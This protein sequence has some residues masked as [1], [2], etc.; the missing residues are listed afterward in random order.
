MRN[1]AFGP[2]WQ[3]STVPTRDWTVEHLRKYLGGRAFTLY[4]H[5]TC[6]V[7]IGPG[8][9]DNSKANERLKGVVSQ[10]PDFKV[11]RHSDGNFLVTF[12]GG[13]GGV[14][15]GTI[16]EQGL[17]RL[18]HEATTLGMLP[19]EKLLTESNDAAAE[20]DMIAGLY[21]RARLYRDVEDLDVVAV[22]R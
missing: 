12:K 3:P 8:D 13:V 21:V 18:R 4:S 11:Q 6:V 7:W 20:L 5:G 15:S 2:A 22:V 9:L 17:D 14:M 10:N 19:S 16:L 1:E